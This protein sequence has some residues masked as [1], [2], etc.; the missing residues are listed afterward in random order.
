MTQQAENTSGV[1]NPTP[2][3]N[4]VTIL[5]RLVTNIALQP[6]TLLLPGIIT[7]LR[8]RPM[9][10]VTATPLIAMLALPIV[11]GPMVCSTPKT[12]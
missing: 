4:W 12:L 10:K 5:N 3:A 2:K 11:F 6:S 7:W 1:D 9:M 8:R